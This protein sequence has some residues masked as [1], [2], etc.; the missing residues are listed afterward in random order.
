MLIAGPQEYALLR[1]PFAPQQVPGLAS[2]LLPTATS[3]SVASVQD[4]LSSGNPAT[5]AGAAQP[6]GVAAANGV[7]M[8]SF[9]GTTNALTWPLHA[10]N[11]GTP[12][13]AWFAWI[14]PGV[15]SGV[16]TLI[17][18]TVASGCSASRLTVQI[19]N[20]DVFVNI[21]INN[22]IA[23]RG[24]AAGI[25]ALNTLLFLSAEFD[26]AQIAESD[27]LIITAN[28]VKQTLSFANDSGTP[29]DMPDTLVTPTGSTLVGEIRASSPLLPYNGRIGSQYIV[30]G[31]GG[32][33]GGG[34]VSA[35]DRQRLMN[36]MRPT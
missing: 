2:W 20:T 22:S 36:H 6:T 13:W 31:A 10:G 17:G 29:N 12:R 15:V 34:C 18:A 7:P 28:C 19:N 27:E 23:R 16:Q 32:F 11:N 24:T 8:L 35:A 14:R 26:G 4:V 1:S 33:S 30:H 25:L 5:A 3:G 21:H 9:N